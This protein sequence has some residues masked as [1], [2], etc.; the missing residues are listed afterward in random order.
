[1]KN[2][3]LTLS[4]L[5]LFSSIFT[6]CGAGWTTFQEG[7]WNGQ[8]YAFQ[9]RSRAGMFAVT[10]SLDWRIKVGKLPWVP[11]NALTT[12]W[13]P[14]YSTDIYGTDAYGFVSTH[15]TSYVDTPFTPGTIGV[16]HTM[17]YISPRTLSEE[18][19]E[20]FY[21]FMQEEWPRVE[22]SVVGTDHR[23]FPHII[24]TV[25]GRQEKYV[26]DYKG[27]HEGKPKII[28]IEPDGRVR[29]IDDDKWANES[30]SG[31][32]PKVHMPGKVLRLCTDKA[33]GGLTMDSLRSFRDAGG[34]PVDVVFQI[35][36][37]IGADCK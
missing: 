12:D 28:R 32:A 21:R 1:M 10:N 7:T 29:F 13:G 3:L 34:R 6:S 9:V 17:L 15:D 26:R 19:Y 20:T 23:E 35:D 8:Q 2:T 30:W 11:V 4:L 27:A 24:G 33:S 18:N 37:G 14:P 36:T 16:K 5:T 25:Y 22:D 31:L